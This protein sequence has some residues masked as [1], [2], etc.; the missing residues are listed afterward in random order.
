M[1]KVTELVHLMANDIVTLR[2]ITN[3]VGQQQPSRVWDPVSL[4][5]GDNDATVDA[6]LYLVD[7]PSTRPVGPV[8][9]GTG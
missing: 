4:G 9:G 1:W 3:V 7:P 2:N 8:P 5:V 6:S